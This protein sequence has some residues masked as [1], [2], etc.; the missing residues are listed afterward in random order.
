MAREP[1]S[2]D[3]PLA[4]IYEGENY[5]REFYG[6][7]PALADAIHENAWLSPLQVLRE[8]RTRYR[9]VAGARR[10]RALQL[11]VERGDWPD[12]TVPCQ[13]YDDLTEARTA[14][15]NAAE[16]HCRLNPNHA[17]LFRTCRELRERFG[18]PATEIA[19]RLDKSV[20]HVNN[21][22][23]CAKQLHPSILKAV[24]NMGDNAIPMSQLIQLASKTPADQL[25]AWEAKSAVTRPANNASAASG[26]PRKRVRALPEI[27]KAIKE[28]RD[29]PGKEHRFACEVLRWV[30][31]GNEPW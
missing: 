12:E 18:L 20:V 11:L 6:D 4:H 9:I 19:K 21:C 22:I 26:E 3:I 1:R 8:S 24:A 31:G 25:E 2:E 15:L 5:S 23:R 16:N 7:I 14:A 13:V 28:L 29:M 27:E 30:I 10:F 17:E